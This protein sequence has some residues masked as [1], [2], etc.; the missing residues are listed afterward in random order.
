MGIESG[1]VIGKRYYKY[2]QG[3][4]T[5]LGE[6]I[7]FWVSTR[8]G[9]SI[10]DEPYAVFHLNGKD[11]DVPTLDLAYYKAILRCPDDEYA[12]QLTTEEHVAFPPDY[13]PLVGK[14]YTPEK[15]VLDKQA[16]FYGKLIEGEKNRYKKSYSKY[17]EAI[18]TGGPLRP[19]WLSDIDDHD[20]HYSYFKHCTVRKDT[21][22]AQN[23][24][25]R[26]LAC[27]RLG[28]FQKED[29]G[30]FADLS[31]EKAPRICSSRQEVKGT[32]PFIIHLFE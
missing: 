24:I 26:Y 20:D 16:E 27:L 2:E 31:D 7:R 13:V 22:A 29:H 17:L 14:G 21:E 19:S 10:Y 30:K 5:D 6:Y 12:A 15:D 1:L 25:N 3:K 18:S 23:L 28:V 9:C 4:R 11:Y 8:N 32:H